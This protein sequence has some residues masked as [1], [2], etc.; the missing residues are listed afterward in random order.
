LDDSTE[1]AH[2]TG[3]FD[4]AG[5]KSLC[6]NW[7]DRLESEKTGVFFDAAVGSYIHAL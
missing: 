5:R 4:T 2:A 3:R 6:K 7:F 1:D